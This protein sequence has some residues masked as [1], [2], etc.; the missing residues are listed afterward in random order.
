[1]FKYPPMPWI[2]SCWKMPHDERPSTKPNDEATSHRK[3]VERVSSLYSP[4][5]PTISSHE[6]DPNN[7]FKGT[8]MGIVITISVPNWMFYTRGDAKLY[9]RD[10]EWGEGRKMAASGYKSV[11]VVTCVTKTLPLQLCAVYE[12]RYPVLTFVSPRG[13][14]N[15]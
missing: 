8:N 14:P 2:R 5:I 11:S 3:N 1:M 15:G 7:V 12:P 6:P 9:I 10:V 4:R 13:H